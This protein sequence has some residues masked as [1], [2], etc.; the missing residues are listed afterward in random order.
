MNPDS[1]LDLAIHNRLPLWVEFQN[2]LTQALLLPDG[3]KKKKIPAAVFHAHLAVR[4][5][6]P[7]LIQIQGRIDRIL[8]AAELSCTDAHN[9]TVL[10]SNSV[11]EEWGETSMLGLRPANLFA[12]WADVLRAEQEA[13]LIPQAETQD[14]DNR[15]DATAPSLQL[16][17]PPGHPCHAKELHIALACWQSLY[18]QE[19]HP[20]KKMS[21]AETIHW[22]KK[23]H[24][25]LSSAAAG[26]I[27]TIISPSGP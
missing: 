4:P 5:S 7:T 15:Q 1:V 6:V 27:A 10:V 17:N 13:G 11:G 18:A 19:E 20:C 2:V 9:N 21:K 3:K 14:I 26:R 25:A 24:P 16:P 22:I 23:Q 8:I 12:R